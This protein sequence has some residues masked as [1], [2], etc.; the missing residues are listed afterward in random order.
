MV[1]NGTWKGCVFPR[2]KKLWLKVKGPTGW[3][4]VPTS[5]HLGGEKQAAALLAR[6][7]DRLLAG[8]EVDGLPGPV[9]VSR[10]SKRWLETRKG[11]SVDR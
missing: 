7:R 1:K 4:Q 10:W 6:V 9:T 2:G 8:E 11:P 5:L 3:R